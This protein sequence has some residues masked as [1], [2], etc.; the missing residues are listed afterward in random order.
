MY[1]QEKPAVTA[2]QGSNPTRVIEWLNARSEMEQSFREPLAGLPNERQETMSRMAEAL[3]AAA[4]GLPPSGVAT[5]AGVS[6]RLLQSWLETD[7]AF[8]EAM[9]SASQLAAAHG[10]RPDGPLTPAMIRVVV[11]AIGRG[12]SWLDAARA[13]GIPTR[14]FRALWRSTPAFEA[15]MRAAQQARPSRVTPAVPRR[16]RL[17]AQ[18]ANHRKYRLVLRDDPPAVLPEGAQAE[19][20]DSGRPRP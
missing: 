9:K 15:L 17:G 8:A 12:D 3:Q 4:H 10:Y 7:R 16:R 18:A 13:A 2:E 11:T 14:G 5:W 19:Q 20:A 1:E 6:T